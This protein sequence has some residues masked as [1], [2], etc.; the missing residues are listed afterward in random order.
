[1]STKKQI[2]KKHFSKI[3]KLH[4]HYLQQLTNLENNKLSPYNFQP[5]PKLYFFYIFQLKYYYKKINN[6]EKQIYKKYKIY[7]NPIHKKTNYKY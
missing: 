1:M 3:Q 7:L 4:N 6:L 5:T 2:S